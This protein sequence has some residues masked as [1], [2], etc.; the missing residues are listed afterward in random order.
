VIVTNQGRNMA[1]AS[2]KKVFE[3]FVSKIPW[4]LAG[5]EMRE[6][7]GQFGP[8]KKCLLPFTCKILHE[9]LVV[10]CLLCVGCVYQD[11]ETGF[12]R[13]F[14]WIGFTTE[15]GLNNA[16]QKD[17][18]M[19][20]GAKVRVKLPQS[21][22]LA[23]LL[24]VQSPPTEPL[25]AGRLLKVSSLATAVLASSGVYLYKQLDLNDLS[26]IRFGRAA[27]TREANRDRDSR[28]TETPPQ[29]ERRKWGELAMLVKERDFT[30]VI[31]IAVYIYIP[32]KLTTA[33]PSSQLLDSLF[34]GPLWFTG[35]HTGD[36][37]AEDITAPLKPLQ[38]TLLC[39]TSSIPTPLTGLHITANQVMRELDM[40]NQ[41]KAAGQDGI[42]L[43]VLKT[44][45]TQLCGVLQLL[46]NLGLHLQIV[47]VLWITSCLVTVPKRGHPAALNDYRPIAA[48]SH[49]MKVMERLVLEYLR[50]KVCPSQDLLQFA[51]QP[52]VG[53]DD[54]LLYLLQKAYFS[55]DR[56]NT[57]VRLFLLLQRLQHHPAQTAEGETGG[58][59]AIVGS[60]ES[61]GEEEYSDL[62]DHFMRWCG[63][64]HLQLNVEKTKEM[65]VNFRRNTSLPVAQVCFNGTDVEIVTLYK[66]LGIQLEW[67]TNIEM[68]AAISYDYLTAFKH[69]E[70]GTEEYWGLKSKVTGQTKSGSEAHH[71]KKNIKDRYVARIGVTGAPPWSQAWGWG[72]QASA[73]WPGLCPRDP[74]GLSPKWRRG[75][76]LP[77]GSPPAGSLGSGTQ[78][79]ERGWTLHYSGVAQG[80]RRRAAVWACFIA[81]PQL[82][83]PHV[84]EFTPVNERVASLR[85]RVGDR[86][87]AVVCAYGPNSS[88]EYPAFLESLGGVLDSA[89]T[90]DSIVLLG[91]F[92]AHVGNNSDTWRGVIGRNGLP[93]LNPSGVLLL[94]FC[95]SHG[96]SI[97][98][99]M[100]KHKGVHQ[101][102]W[103][104]AQAPGHPR[105][106][107]N[108]H[109]RKSFSQIPREAGDIESEWTMF[110]ASIVDGSSKLW[111]CGRKVSGACRHGGNPRT[112]WWT[113]EVR[114]AVRLKKESYR[115]MLACGTPDAVDRYRQAKQA[116]ART[117]L[118]AKTL[119]SGRS[120][121]PGKVYA[122][123]LERRIRP[124]VDPR[125][126]E[127]QCGFRPGRGT[128]D[129]LYTLRRVLRGFMGV[130]PTSPHVLCGSGEGIRPC[131]SWY[132][133]GSAPR[134]WGPGPLLRA[135]RSLYDRSRSLVRIAGSK[136]DLFPVHV[137]LRQGCPLSP[138]LFIIF[139][140]RISRRSQGPEGVRFGNHRI[141]SLLFADDVVLLASSSQDLQHVLERFAAECEAA[142][143]RISTSKSEAM[144][145][146]RKRVVCPLRVHL[147]SAERL[148]DL[149]C[150]NRGT[151]IKVGQHLGALD[152]L[153]P[154][155]Y[156]STLKVL[157]SRAPQSRME[158]IQQVIREDLGKELSELF[159]SFEE[160]PQGA[161]SLA[162]VHKAVLHDGRTV[163]V[164]VQHPKVQR[165][166]SKDIVVMEVL[167]RVV[168][169]LFPDFAFMWLVE[170]AKKNMP[171]ELDFLNEGHN[172]ERVAKMLAHFPFLKIP[173]I[174]WNLSTKRILTMEFAEGGQVNDRD[175]MK[176]QGINVNELPYHTAALRQEDALYCSPVEVCQELRGESSTFQLPEEEESLLSLLYQV[177]CVYGPVGVIIVRF[178]MRPTMV[179]SSANFTMVFVEWMAEQSLVKR[180]KRPWAEHA[181][182]WCASAQDQCRGCVVPH[183]HH[184]RP[185]RSSVHGD[186][187]YEPEVRRF[188]S[189]G[190]SLHGGG[191]VAGEMPALPSQ[192]VALLPPQA[193]EAQHGL[194]DTL[195]LLQVH[196][197]ED[198]ACYSSCT[199]LNHKTLQRVVKIAQHITRTE[200]P[201]MEDLYT[202]QCRKKADRII[203]D[204]SH[205]RH[206]QFCMLP[207]GQGFDRPSFSPLT[208]PNTT[209]RLQ[210][211]PP[212]HPSPLTTHL[213]SDFRRIYVG[214]AEKEDQEGT[215]IQRHQ[216]G[217]EETTMDSQDC[218]ENH[219]CQPACPH[220]G[221]IH[222]QSQISENLG[223][224]YSEMIFVH[225]FVHCDPHPG[226]VLVRKCPQGKKTE[227]VLLDHGLYQG[228]HNAI[229]AQREF[230]YTSL[231]QHFKAGKRICIFLTNVFLLNIENKF[232]FI[233]NSL[234]TQYVIIQ[235]AGATLSSHFGYVRTGWLTATA[236]V[237]CT[238]VVSSTRPT[239]DSIDVEIR[240]NAALY[241]PQISE[242]L[243]RVPRADAV[244]AEDQ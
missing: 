51:Y 7:F 158:E 84:L 162:Q 48:T 91:D 93:D 228:F 242:L 24:I 154:E 12:H 187:A 45:A 138:V 53:V 69:V 26:V 77:V 103:H 23:F 227:I 123:V 30:G 198:P 78:L 195:Q 199:A 49:I 180:V 29:V 184:L 209:N 63:E 191:L 236:L 116:A 50:P 124:I 75:P 41:G 202:Q 18:H 167:L 25:M 215:R 120:S 1:A 230:I 31:V 2:S 143:M 241:L 19:L 58:H 182:L 32:R 4:T 173:M 37:T 72:S 60:V 86:S 81:P 83:L 131:P 190:T 65:V 55:L 161:A 46:F 6:Y 110:S 125:I 92:N 76:R 170:E 179:V 208:R 112:R 145:L 113:P 220:S 160:K 17:P 8:V 133:V 176:K 104:Q 164:K 157:H 186:L 9:F 235:V 115:T 59:A 47:P 216:M 159:V 107:F 13:G 119:G 168:H 74:A 239:V 222:V 105:E 207:S 211:L 218:R 28:R 40:L 130:C 134:V 71:E 148:R 118:E 127:E 231:M 39:T 146:D 188:R 185:V 57:T 203:K 172:A 38:Q 36:L 225:G 10:V 5:K 221:L 142:G 88:T 80:E 16:L 64:N 56:P 106:V 109:L 85:L 163:A 171:L 165:Q 15:E 22:A 174:H 212:P 101:C 68:T 192:T 204:P 232:V 201:S 183:S 122:R 102:T 90:G 97:T 194:Q 219:W 111:S 82:S 33:V 205:P 150:A 166:S 223:K 206:K 20:E 193:T 156:T 237:P 197:R 152:Y 34:T 14:C 181:A 79:L 243:N 121:P 213:H 140:D 226:N 129:Q 61:G 234:Q 135:V 44:C 100:F 89:P 147:R 94:D 62:V 214:F 153:L 217:Q 126:Q 98:N 99:T 132:S 139:M 73:W 52:H 136:S 42:S 233:V 144:V 210:T 244:T 240:T 224:I 70:Y 67:S 27:A 87:L 155:E 200:L 54:A 229:C 108:S 117:V 21:L 114:D 35:P 66:Y 95:A 11:K 149:C 141:S 3:V 177:S 238:P 137:G 96:L 178:D 43:Q 151:F 196:H 169:W 189:P 175:Y 128:V